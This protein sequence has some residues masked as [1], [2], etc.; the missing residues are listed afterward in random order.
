MLESIKAINSQSGSI[1]YDDFD[2]ENDALTQTFGKEKRKRMRGVVSH[3]LNIKFNTSYLS[4][5]AFIRSKVVSRPL[6]KNSSTSLRMSRRLK[7][8][9]DSCQIEFGNL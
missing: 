3:M 5:M 1:P 2:L 7:V 8:T 6:S 9:W 4:W